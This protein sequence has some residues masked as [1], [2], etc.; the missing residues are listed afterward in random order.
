MGKSI[1]LQEAKAKAIDFDAPKERDAYIVGACAEDPSLYEKVVAL[2]KGF[3]EDTFLESPAFATNETIQDTNTEAPGTVIGRY[4]LLQQIGEG[5]MGAVYMADQTEPVTRKVA[6]KIIK[7]GMDT[8]QVVAR[9][10]AERQ[11]LAMMDHPNIAKVLDAGATDSGRP[12]FVMELVRGVPITEYCDKNKLAT[13]ERIEL[14]IAVCQAIQHAHQKGVIHRDIKP[15]NVMVT[16]H[17]GHP[18]PKVIDFGIAKATNQKLT[19][20]TLFTNY[21]QMIGTPAYMSPEQAEMSGLDVDT[22]TDVYSLGVLFY[23]LLT[24]TTPFPSK[25]LMSMGYGEMQ[26]VIAETEPPKPSTRMSTMMHEERTVIAKNRRIDASALGQAFKGDL[27]WIVMQSLEKDR[28]RRYETV[29]ALIADIRRH[30]TNEPVSAAAPSAAY[31]F[32]KFWRRNQAYMVT[33]SIVAGLLIAAVLFS[34]IQA[35][36]ATH[37]RKKA[38]AATATAK[39]QLYHSQVGQ[40]E[41]LQLAGRPGYFTNVV[42]ILSEIAPRAIEEGDHLKLRNIALA[43]IGDSKARERGSFVFDLPN[44][45]Q[46]S[47]VFHQNGNILLGY[48]NGKAATIDLKSRK[49][50]CLLENTHT[51]PITSIIDLSDRGLWITAEQDQKVAKWIRSGDE[52]RWNSE[53]ILDTHQINGSPILL[54]CGTNILISSIGSQIA[55]LWN[56]LTG[57]SPKLLHL[58][59]TFGEV[60]HKSLNVKYDIV[61]FIAAASPDGRYLAIVDSSRQSLAVLDRS[62]NY[63]MIEKL[64]GL[65]GLFPYV[66]LKFSPDGS[67][68][69]IG[70]VTEIALFETEQWSRTQTQRANLVLGGY[71]CDFSPTKPHLIY[72]GSNKFIWDFESNQQIEEIGNLPGTPRFSKDGSEILSLTVSKSHMTTHIAKRR[73]DS[74]VTVSKNH[75]RRVNGVTF[76]PMGRF[77]IS[78][79]ESHIHSTDLVTKSKQQ[80][81]QVKRNYYF[82]DPSLSRDGKLIAAPATIEGVLVFWETKTGHIIHEQPFALPRAIQFHPTRNLLAASNSDGVQL[83][84]YEHTPDGDLEHSG[85]KLTPLKDW[86]TQDIVHTL[87]LSADGR[88]VGWLTVDSMKSITNESELRIESVPKQ[89]GLIHL[90]SER[91]EG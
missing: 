49:E 16:L 31:Q 11:A 78:T 61:P 39:E 51:S 18:V 88:Y 8:K 33:A 81:D 87:R 27:D 34:A 56:P 29:N 55:L 17:D 9:F 1:H 89:A 7:M 70:T 15:S 6:L 68:L 10:E 44:S 24:G 50:V 53:I 43:T 62:K 71:R 20:K 85:L 84:N 72:G 58:P 42:K 46:L 5:G 59:S 69:A 77:L 66:Y 22:R 23:E 91:A 86:A 57:E 40:A 41:A 25:E 54:K 28:T 4:K 2:V 67:L 76:G 30:L 35:A 32:Q 3:T 47:K 12:Y 63:D 36:N 14:F 74:P 45:Q 83:W 38:D 13:R 75:S 82:E 37:A 52:G 64:E 60:Q 73:S 21:A 79:S 65:S 90:W 48:Q 19:E 80:M 26:R